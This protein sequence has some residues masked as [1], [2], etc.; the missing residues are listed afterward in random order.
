MR[1]LTTGFIVPIMA[2]AIMVAVVGCGG[3]EQGPGSTK[4]AKG[5]VSYGGVFRMNET[6]EVP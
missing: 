2:A 4:E 3:G 5:G 6:G 1:K